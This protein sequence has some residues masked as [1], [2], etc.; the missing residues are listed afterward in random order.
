MACDNIRWSRDCDLCCKTHKP[1]PNNKY[2]RT[3]DEKE[4][5]IYITPKQK[6]QE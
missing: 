6:V 2:C 3:K 5:C 4:K 1:L